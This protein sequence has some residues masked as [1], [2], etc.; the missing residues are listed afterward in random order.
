MA[1]GFTVHV[2]GD[3]ELLA[4]LTKMSDGVLDL[5]QE[6]ENTGKYLMDFE[7]QQVFESE[8]QAFGESWQPLSEPYKFLKRFKF[9]NRPILEASGNMRRGFLFT[10]L[11]SRQALFHNV[12]DEQYLK[13]HQTGAP[14]NNL[15]KRVI[16]KLDKD[17]KEGIMNIF[18]E[19]LRKK[20]KQA[21][22]A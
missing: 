5:E 8:G 7:T 19:G 17:R 15:P 6:F 14:R 18:V 10:I 12:Y 2:S 16:Y 21:F 1:L 22:N 20:L 9:P 13:Y 4:G 3:K 11:N